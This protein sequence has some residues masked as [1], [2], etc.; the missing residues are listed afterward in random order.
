[1]DATLA[2][3]MRGHTPHTIPDLIENFDVLMSW[4]RFSDVWINTLFEWEKVCGQ[5]VTLDCFLTA[6]IANETRRW[7]FTA[8]STVAFGYTRFAVLNAVL[9]MAR[10]AKLDVEFVG[11]VFTGH[12]WEATPLQYSKDFYSVKIH[13]AHDFR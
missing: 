8:V 5:E 4:Y 2:I 12:K 3:E 9:N 7:G 1:L 11:Q 6:P 13:Y 10:S